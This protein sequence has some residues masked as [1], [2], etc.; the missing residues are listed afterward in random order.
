[1]TLPDH[2][3]IR[4]LTQNGPRWEFFQAVRFIQRLHPEAVPIGHQGPPQQEC[5]R[6]EPTADLGFPDADVAAIRSTPTAEGKPRYT[7]EST[8]LSLLGSQS[9]L[10]AHFTEAV[11]QD[12]SDESL[13]KEFL[14]LF[15]HRLQ[16]L[17]FRAWEKYRYPIQ[18]QPMGKDPLS[19]RLMALIGVA[20]EMMPEGA[21]IPS[22]R[23]LAF[24]GLLTQ[25]PRSASALRGILFEY[26][27]DIEF[28]VEQCSS[29]WIPIAPEQHNRLGRVNA[30]LGQDLCIGDRIFDRS[31]SFTV[32]VG[33][34][35]L[36][37]F[38]TFLPGA[39]KL[40]RMRELVDLFNSDNLD[41]YVNLRLRQEEV[42]QL[43]LAT[44]TALLGWSTWLGKRPDT[45]QDV[46]FLMKG[47]LHGR[48]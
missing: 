48:R 7:I 5:V 4:S 9:P 2:P 18:F 38:M 22:V 43:N 23:I 42:P 19:K 35:G 8:F 11:I 36:E 1:M 30:R 25:M 46:R 28:D 10:P 24:A 29:Q 34:L 21:R 17:F 16:S 12:D 41:Y 47:W 20:T 44:P 32:H 27:E 6:F 37:I 31:C 3:V 33:P 14:D 39:D 15:H 26:F 40:E 13:V 45:D